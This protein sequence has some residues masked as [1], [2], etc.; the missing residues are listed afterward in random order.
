MN[1]I[2]DYIHHFDNTLEIL[3][4][5]T[6]FKTSVLKE[7]IIYSMFPGGKRLRPLLIYA[8]GELFNMPLKILDSIAIAI[9]CIHSY[10]LIHDDL[11]AMDNDD[12]RRGKPS[13]HKAFS[14]AIAILTGDALQNFAIDYLLSSLNGQIKDK[15]LIQLTQMLLKAEGYEG[16]ITGQILDLTLLSDKKIT[17]QHINNIHHMKTGALIKAALLMPLHTLETLPICYPLIADIADDFGLLFQMQDDYLDAYADINTHG[18]GRRSDEEN[19]KKTFTHFYSKQDLKVKI[20]SAYQ[21]I[22]EK[23]SSIEKPWPLL[24]AILKAQF[25]K[26]REY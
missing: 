24:T 12:F 20:D 9:E 2:N 7:A 17:E 22:F 4:T 6:N 3:L 23:I 5:Q 16:M 8:T 11:P 25:D 10:S 21:T 19:N 18:K 1:T 14:E 26:I 13:C 15:L